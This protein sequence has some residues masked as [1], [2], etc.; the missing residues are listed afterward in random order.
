MICLIRLPAV[1]S[2]RFA[3]TNICMPLGLAYIAA[4]LEEAGHKVQV[5][6][7]VGEA[8]EEH[9]NCYKGYLI[10]LNLDELVRRIPKEAVKVGISVIFTH[11]WPILVALVERIKIQRPDLPIILG[12]EH[13][14]SMPEFC[15]LTSKSDYLV[16]GEGEET[17]VELVAALDNNSSLDVIDGIAYRKD[18]LAVVNRRRARQRD[19]DAIHLPSWKHFKISTYHEHRFVGGMFSSEITMPILAT[20]GCP[21]QCTYC[22]APNMWT[23]RWVARDPIKVVDEIESYVHTYGAR[24]FPFQDMTAIIRRSWIVAFC[25]ELISRDLGITWQ[26]ASGTRSEAIDE[27][28]ADLLYRSGMTSMSYAP[29]SGSESTRRFIKKRMQTEALFSSIDAASKAS[30]NVAAFLVIGF[31]H[32][33]AEHMRENLPFVDQV[34]RS[35]ITDLSIGF[36]VAMPGTELFANLFDTG[37]IKLDREYFRH[38]LASLSLIPGQSHSLHLSKLEL[39]LWKLRLILRFYNE[40][41][42]NNSSGEGFFKLLKNLTVGLFSKSKHQSKLQTAFRNGITTG[43]ESIRSQFGPRWI[44]AREERE[45]FVAWDGIFRHIRQEKLRLKV[46]APSLADST[47]LH[48]HNVA[49][50]LRKEHGSSHSIGLET[51]DS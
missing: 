11:E 38:I 26:L 18:G 21:Y 17:I 40:K 30:L 51:I 50:L 3:T 6:D 27:T 14:T 33:K 9:T 48:R 32:D 4:A 10:G 13:I 5:L 37:K 34:A 22:S 46:I 39:S 23:T 42:Q 12:G 43:L 16:L 28:V 8:P 15:L 24:N 44:P 25:Q 29:E 7:A 47:D 19:I 41:S 31:P 49:P 45:M 1:E 20:R 2:F 36:F 35:G